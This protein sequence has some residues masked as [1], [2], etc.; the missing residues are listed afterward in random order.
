MFFFYTFE[1]RNFVWFQFDFNCLFSIVFQLYISF[2]VWLLLLAA[3]WQ[4][5]INCGLSEEKFNFTVFQSF[6][7]LN[8]Q[9]SGF[10]KLS[11]GKI[12]CTKAKFCNCN[13]FCAISIYCEIHLKS[14]HWNG[15]VNVENTVST[16]GHTWIGI[17]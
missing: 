3:V 12:L 16:K 6:I 7:V 9:R 5:D 15:F 1:R 10:W 17:Q 4:I 2:D 8:W 14:R 11:S 13:A